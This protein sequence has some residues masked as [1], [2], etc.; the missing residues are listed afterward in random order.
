MK[1]FWK[2][3]RVARTAHFRPKGAA[4]AEITCVVL[5]GGIRKNVRFKNRTFFLFFVAG[6]MVIC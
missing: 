4:L 1:K 2:S 3:A 5:E 6:W